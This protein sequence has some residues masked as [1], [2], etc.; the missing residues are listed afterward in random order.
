[1]KKILIILSIAIALLLISI[2]LFIPNRIHISED[3]EV[4]ASRDALLRKL[5]DDSCWY[6]WWPDKKAADSVTGIF[7]PVAKSLH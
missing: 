7:S 2:Y 5:G 4:P 1:M 3:E 6:K